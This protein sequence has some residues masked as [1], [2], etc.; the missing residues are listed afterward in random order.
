F[1]IRHNGEP[2]LMLG[3]VMQDGWNGLDLGKAL[4]AEQKAIS[5]EL[6]AGLT[7]SKVTDQAVN[8]G[9]AV[10]EFMLKFFVALGV[11]MVVGL[12]SL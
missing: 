12:V 10:D 11:V 3:I 1:L 6:P 2:A 7:F 5:A 8:I 9:E 4:E